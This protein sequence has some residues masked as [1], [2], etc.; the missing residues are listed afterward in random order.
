MVTARLIMKM[1]GG[2]TKGTE[3]IDYTDWDQVD[4]FGDLMAARCAAPA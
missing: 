3:V 4:R 2:P 1:T